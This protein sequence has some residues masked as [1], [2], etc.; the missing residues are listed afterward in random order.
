MTKYFIG[1]LVL[2]VIGFAGFTVAHRGDNKPKQSASQNPA[3]PKTLVEQVNTDIQKG[4]VLV[5]VRT[6]EEYAVKH[7]KGAIN[8]PVEHIQAGDFG[9]LAK[10]Q[11]IY[12]YCH[13]GRRAGIALDTLKQ[14][15]YQHISSI[16][17]LSNWEAKGG[18]T[19]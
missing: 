14:A 16:V 10:D 17:S 6:A 15:G 5:D 8:L 3:K 13:S 11:T 9:T 2:I 1:L 4:A 7:A 18:P 12:L 19:E